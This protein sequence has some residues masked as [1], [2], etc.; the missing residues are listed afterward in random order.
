MFETKIFRTKCFSIA[1]IRTKQFSNNFLGQ[2]V[3]KQK[4]M[5]NDF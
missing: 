2:D 1:L 3:L 4:I 5:T